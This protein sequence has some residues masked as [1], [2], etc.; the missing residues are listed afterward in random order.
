MA[1]DA[2]TAG[3]TKKAPATKAAIDH[4]PWVEKYRPR[5]VDDLVFQSEVVAVLNKVLQGADLPNILFYGPPGTGKTSAAVALCRQMF[6]T[7]ETF[8]DRVLELNASDERGIQVVRTKIKEF[9]QRSVAPS[10][11]AGSC[12]ALKI[13]ILDEADAMTHA[14]Q[15][16]MR[17]TME[18]YSKTTRFFLICNYISRIIDPLTSRCAKFRFKPLPTESQLERMS[19]ICTAENVSLDEESLLTLIGLC[20]GD[21]RKSITYLQSLASSHQKI[22]AEFIRNMTGMVDDD[23]VDSVLSACQSLDGDKLLERINGI[24]R[25]GHGARQLLNQLYDRL[26]SNCDLSDYHKAV[27]FEKI[28]VAEA[29]LMDGADEYLQLLDVSFCIQNQFRDKAY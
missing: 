19:F 11:I 23:T 16:A 17:R 1:F 13:I 28:A 22:D 4:I 14:A 8:K 27:A 6:K 26:I 25:E 2:K 3:V 7:N 10:S 24:R 15:A 18:K 5:K 9:A 21:L 12:A 20:E 29:R